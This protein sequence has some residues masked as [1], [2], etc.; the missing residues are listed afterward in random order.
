VNTDGGGRTGRTWRMRRMSLS[1]PERRLLSVQQSRHDHPTRRTT[2]HTDDNTPAP[3]RLRSPTV[4]TARAGPCHQAATTDDH[5]S[6]PPAGH[7]A[8]PPRRRSSRPPLLQ[9]IGSCSNLASKGAADART[10]PAPRADKPR[11][12]PT[13]SSRGMEPRCKSIATVIS[14]RSMDP[15]TIGKLSEGVALVHSCKKPVW[16][17]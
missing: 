15:E 2:G 13:A 5:E 11:R 1:M 6:A 9:Q 8:V 17:R 16:P 3:C 10:D 7:P 14:M 4:H 12:Y